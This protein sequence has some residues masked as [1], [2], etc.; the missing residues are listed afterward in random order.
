MEKGLKWG[1]P[2]EQKEITLRELLRFASLE[3][4]EDSGI[5][6]HFAKV[7]NDREILIE[8]YSGRKISFKNEVYYPKSLMVLQSRDFILIKG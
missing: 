2:K 4:G 1:M 3:S 5:K 6:W 8:T 7:H